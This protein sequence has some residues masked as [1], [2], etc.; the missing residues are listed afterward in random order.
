MKKTLLT[1]LAASMALTANARIDEA[2]FSDNFKLQLDTDSNVISL[3][4]TTSGVSGN[5]D[6]VTLPS[7]ME[8]AGIS[9]AYQEDGKT[10]ANIVET[11]G[12]MYKVQLQQGQQLSLT[13]IDNVGASPVTDYSG[14]AD[15]GVILAN[16]NIW[17][18]NGSNLG[19]SYCTSTSPVSTTPEF[20]GEGNLS[21]L[22]LN[23]QDGSSKTFEE[24]SATPNITGFKAENGQIIIEGEPLH[25]YTIEKSIG[26]LDF[27]N[28][29]TTETYVVKLEDSVSSFSFNDPAIGGSSIGSRADG[30]G[31]ADVFYRAKY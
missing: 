14:N 2:R 31:N 21:E 16:G 7:S 6:L 25:Q 30:K 19:D 11:D 20:D 26:D 18:L 23:Y 15:R 13:Y 4:P 10:F 1:A 3:A 5:F 27:T 9:D 24:P 28:S 12:D 8:P 29:A 22:V 17:T